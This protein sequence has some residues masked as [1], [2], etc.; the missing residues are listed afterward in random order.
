VLAYHVRHDLTVSDLLDSAI[1]AGVDVEPVQM[2]SVNKT[3]NVSE[4]TRD[5][6]IPVRLV[7]HGRH[8]ALLDHTVLLREVG[9]GE[10]LS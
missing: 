8:I 5:K 1:L 4:R 9:F 7:V 2:L 10:C 3:R 6:H